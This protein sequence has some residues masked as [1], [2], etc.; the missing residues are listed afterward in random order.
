MIL[1]THPTDPGAPPQRS[2]IQWSA[3]EIIAMV[4]LAL[5][6]VAG[7]IGMWQ[8]MAQVEQTM[9]Q[10]A[11]QLR[12]DRDTIAGQIRDAK[13]DAAVMRDQV[14]RIREDIA[15]LRGTLFGRIERR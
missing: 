2:R 15:G 1:T 4:A 11:Q 7:A 8:R 5:P 14:G 13:A 9:R 3:G 10:M 6:L 12:D